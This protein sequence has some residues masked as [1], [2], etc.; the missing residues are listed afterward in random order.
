VPQVGHVLVRPV[1]GA[2]VGEE[3]VDHQHG[4]LGAGARRLDIGAGER[5]EQL[6]AQQPHVVLVRDVVREVLIEELV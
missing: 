5:G 6:V 1:R 3:L 4:V 2:L